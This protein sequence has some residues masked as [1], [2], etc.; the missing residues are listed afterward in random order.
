MDAGTMS[1]LGTDGRVHE[2]SDAIDA[3]DTDEWYF[4]AAFYGNSSTSLSSASVVRL[5]ERPAKAGATGLVATESESARINA[6]PI[7]R[8]LVGL[9]RRCSSR[10]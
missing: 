6:H 5:R 8:R 4:F 9:L 2:V 7:A 10:G 1:V 3:A